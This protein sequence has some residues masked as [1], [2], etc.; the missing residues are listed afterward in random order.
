MKQKVRNNSSYLFDILNYLFLTL[1]FIICIYPFYYIFI[2]SVSNPTEVQKGITILPAGLTFSCYSAVFK[3][4]G[5]LNATVISILRTIIGTGITVLAC[6]F[7]SYLM[8]KNELPFRKLIY[9]FVIITMYFNAGLIP[10]YFTMKMYHLNNNFLLYVV[11]TAISAYYVILIK[12]FIEQLPAALEESATIDGAGYFTIFRKI[13]FPLSKPIVATILVFAAVGQWN[14]WFDNFFLVQSSRLKT[15]QLILYDYLNEAN[16]LA[17][18]SNNDKIRGMN[19]V[20]TPSSIR[21][22]ITMVVTLPIIFVYPFMQRYFVKGIMMGA[23]K[24]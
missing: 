15:L 10:W 20:M 7:F 2:Y 23:V 5:I 8:T 6:T 11:P 14:S 12:T 9:R 19:T 17:A 4:N 16:R 1:L 24:G 22:T 13:I 18:A 21:M 3:L